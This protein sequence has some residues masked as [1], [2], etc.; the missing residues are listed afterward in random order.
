[1]LSQIILFLVYSAAMASTIFIPNYAKLLNI[2]ES[3]IGII[4]FAYGIAV[5][6][7]SYL[8]GRV[9]DFKSRKLVV[10]TGL[11]MATLFFL[12]QYFSRNEL[13][14]VAVRFLAGFSMGTILPA[15]IA[16]SYEAGN[17]LGN[18]S[19]Y[20]SLGWA[21]GSI[22]AGVVVS[23]FREAPNPY[24]VAF[25]SSSTLFFIAFLLSF[26]LDESN[27]T[28]VSVPLFPRELIRKNL[29]VYLANF[30]RHLGANAIWII[31][32]LYLVELGAT[33]S[34]IGFLYLANTL[35]QYFIMRR[36]DCTNAGTLI[37]S[38]LVLSMVVF[39]LYSLATSYL[40][41]LPIQLLLASSYA[42]VYVGS[43]RYIVERATEK[44]TSVGILNSSISLAIAL[45]PVI[46]GVIAENFG[47]KATMQFASFITALALVVYYQLR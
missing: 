21:F 2:G 6:L 8:M 9:A 33:P 38:G 46:G 20:G 41:I 31:F 40:Q 39:Y 12:L 5:F 27:F 47:Y 26:K 7:A 44:A 14:L 42:L 11:G 35:A 32:P 25:I 34:W 23:L 15:L 37:S 30:L 19:S 45:G 16:Y 29:N 22:L 1:M 24:G 10:T 36:L 4:G 13:S 43:L 3:K 17:R 28:P 18:L